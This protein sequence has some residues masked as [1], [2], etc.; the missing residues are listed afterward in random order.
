[1]LLSLIKIA[2]LALCVLI[3]TNQENKM[4]FGDWLIYLGVMVSNCI[5]LIAKGMIS[6]LL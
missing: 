3:T 4:L 2:F 6:F 5:H 1:M